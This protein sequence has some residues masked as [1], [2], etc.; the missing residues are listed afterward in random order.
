MTAPVAKTFALA[1]GGHPRARVWVI[2]HVRSSISYSD[3]G[4]VV[5][6][7]YGE[8]PPVVILIGHR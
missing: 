1:P 6:E 5:K 8:D 4:D 7:L 3:V 2:T